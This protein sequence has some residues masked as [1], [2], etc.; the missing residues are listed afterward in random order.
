MKITTRIDSYVYIHQKGQFLQMNPAPKVEIGLGQLLFANVNHDMMYSLESPYIQKSEN[1][2]S[3][4]DHDL[5]QCVINVSSL[6]LST[7]R[8]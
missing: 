4:N 3:A 8:H 7:A 5:D 2:S 6:L 1:C